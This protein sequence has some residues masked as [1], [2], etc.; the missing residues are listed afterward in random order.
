M[1]KIYKYISLFLILVI[2]T[3]CTHS[4]EMSNKK[5]NSDT[6]DFLP[7]GTIVKI[8]EKG[9]MMI[10]GIGQISNNYLYDYIGYPYPEGY[11]GNNSYL[12]NKGDIMEILYLG[13]STEESQ[14][15]ISDIEKQIT[16]YVNQ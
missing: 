4:A 8:K 10:A 15:Y 13:Y 3:G 12:F 1:R 2:L 7:I 6:N 9:K 11:T 14:E 5:I 16:K